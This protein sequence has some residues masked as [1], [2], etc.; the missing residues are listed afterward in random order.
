MKLIC[1]YTTV[2]A[3][4]IENLSTFF[5]TSQNPELKVRQFQHQHMPTQKQQHD[6]FDLALI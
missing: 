5:L 4:V 2:R 6:T 1:S 3:A